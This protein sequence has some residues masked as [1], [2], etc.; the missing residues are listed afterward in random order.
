MA[1]FR[2]KAEEPESEPAIVVLYDAG[3]EAELLE[4]RY[5]LG[6]G[7][8]HVGRDESCSIQVLDREVSRKQLCIQQDFKAGGF[9]ASDPGSANG[10]YVNGRRL[11]D[12][13]VLAEGDLIE[14]GRSR[15]VFTSKR[16]EGHVDAIMHFK[17]HGE[18]DKGT[19]RVEYGDDDPPAE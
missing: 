6:P 19:L 9:V 12:P 13:L 1:L 3:Q 14:V 2:H 10:T 5:P 8:D 15:L 7:T 17:R 4:F 18:R 11:V 16:F